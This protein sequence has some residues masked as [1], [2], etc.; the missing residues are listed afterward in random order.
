M[1]TVSSKS[2]IPICKTVIPAV[3]ILIHG[4]LRCISEVTLRTWPHRYF[5][6]CVSFITYE[7]HS[8]TTKRS[9]TSEHV[10][11]SSAAK[12]QGTCLYP[13]YARRTLKYPEYAR[14]APTK[15]LLQDDTNLPCQ[16][17]RWVRLDSF[18]VS[19]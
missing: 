16:D 13:Q 5:C 1:V 14:S 11:P 2:A 18:A 10:D 3:E 4:E 19:L 6:V 7:H 17:P 8:T 15:L 9:I 12:H